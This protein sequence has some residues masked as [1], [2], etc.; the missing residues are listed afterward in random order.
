[1][2]HT[3]ITPEF[4]AHKAWDLYQTH[5]VPIEVSIDILEAKG[6]ALDQDLLN[7]LIEDHQSLSRSSST[8]QFKSGLAGDTTKT[9][10]LHTTTHIL[11]KVLRDM[12]GDEVKQKGSAI[13]DQKARFDF[14]LDDKLTPEQLVELT[15]KIQSII[16]HN[17]S[18]TSA[19]MSESQARELGA[20]GLFG[21]KYGDKVTVYTLQDEQGNVYSREFCGGPHVTSTQ[22]I[23]Q[24]QILKQK[25]IGAGLKRIEFDVQ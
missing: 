10:A 4:L 9:R 13:T 15:N 21:E 25:S 24:F 18:M 3:T 2:D 14:T 8:G 11:H 7:K 5:G 1:M 20:I 17:L 23:G 22:E 19:E 6:I 16:D 12:F